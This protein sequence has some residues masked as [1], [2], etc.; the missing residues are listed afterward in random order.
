VIGLAVDSL[1]A[2]PADHVAQILADAHSNV[3][4]DRLTALRA[5][6]AAENH[7][8]GSVRISSTFADVRARVSPLEEWQWPGTAASDLIP[9]TFTG[10]VGRYQLELQGEGTPVHEAEFTVDPGVLKEVSEPQVVASGG[11]KFPWPIALI[12]AAGAAVASVLLLGGGDDPGPVVTEER[13]SV[14]VILP[15]RR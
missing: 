13:G 14:V 5:V 8:F 3:E 9:F 2:V 11:G 1:E 7:L 12:G 6:A 4:S 10:P 15:H